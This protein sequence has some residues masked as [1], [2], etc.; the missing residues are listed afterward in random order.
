MLDLKQQKPMIEA[1][2]RGVKQLPQGD[3]PPPIS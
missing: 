2:A 1:A 3:A